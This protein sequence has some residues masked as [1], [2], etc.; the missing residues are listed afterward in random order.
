MLGGELLDLGKE[1]KR[2]GEAVG[3]DAIHPV[4]GE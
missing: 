1:A 2:I 3:V 4:I